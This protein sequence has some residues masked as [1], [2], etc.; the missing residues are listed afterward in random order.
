M[1]EHLLRAAEQRRVE[2]LDDHPELEVIALMRRRGKQE[3]VARMALQRLGELVVLG[4]ANLA[5]DSVGG[6]VMRFV[7]DDE[8]PARR[9]EQAL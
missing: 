8:I 3:E 5:A 4:L 1:L 7:E 9:I 6:Q 2:Q